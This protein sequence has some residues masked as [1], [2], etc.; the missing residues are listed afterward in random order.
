MVADAGHAGD[1]GQ[2][3]DRHQPP[4]LVIRLNDLDRHLIPLL[5]GVD[6]PGHDRRP[7]GRSRQAGGDERP[8]GRPGTDRPEGHQD[9]DLVDPRS[10]P[11]ERGEPGAD[12]CLIGVFGS[13]SLMSTT[14]PTWKT[15]YRPSG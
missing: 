15:A 12:D 6:V 5:D 11:A 1:A 13:G 9:G 8:E 2:A 4:A 3:G 14:A 10:G 7:A